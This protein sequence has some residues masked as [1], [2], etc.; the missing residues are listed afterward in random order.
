MCK[1]KQS[2]TFSVRMA[3]NLS[4]GMMTPAVAGAIDQYITQTLGDDDDPTFIRY[5]RKCLDGSLIQ[6]VTIDFSMSASQE[7]MVKYIIRFFDRNGRLSEVDPYRF[8]SLKTGE[9]PEII[10]SIF[11]DIDSWK[12]NGSDTWDRMQ[13][14]STQD[15][16]ERIQNIPMQDYAGSVNVGFV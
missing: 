3:F 15:N 12:D 2:N 10:K 5:Q 1:D 9:G 6:F 14:A 8:Y 16:N 11:D 4:R 13:L 7:E